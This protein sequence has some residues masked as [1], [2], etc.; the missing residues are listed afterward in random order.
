MSA[1]LYV[2]LTT[3]WQER[4][5]IAHGTTRVERGIVAALAA[6][7]VPQLQFCRYERARRSFLPVER[8]EALQVVATKEVPE[9]RRNPPAKWRK[10]SILAMGKRMEVWI[11]RN[12]RDRL[13]Q[14]TSEETLA[15]NSTP[16]FSPSSTVLFPGELQRQDFAVLMQLKAQLSLRLAF[17][18]YD[19]L[20]VLPDDDPRLR[21]PTEHNLPSSDFIAREAA[22]V[23]SIS[24]YSRSMLLDH[25]AKRRLKKPPVD[26]IRLGHTLLAEGARSAPPSGLQ[27]GEFVLT[28]GDVVSR[29]N[30]V[31]LI[32]VWRHLLAVRPAALKPLII[33]GRVAAE[34]AWL[35][36]EIA[37]DPGLTKYVL[38]LTNVNDQQLNWLYANCLFT[39]F[40]SLSEG[41]GLPVAESLA[42]GKVC[43]A[44]SLTS[45]PEASQ[46][47]GIHLDPTDLQSWIVIVGRLLADPVELARQTRQ[48]AAFCRVTWS[49]TAADVLRSL[50]VGNE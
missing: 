45:I 23:L 4:G 44:S 27:P 14:G 35:A 9:A 37:A 42:A 18:F 19:L 46:G 28:V 49:D 30:H 39:V 3:A 33:A 26:V 36:E 7:N 2:D 29:K 34:C 13:Q 22:N 40:P 5:R 24:N 16:F 10:H 25:I 15:R 41:Y 47:F 1:R 11:R 32:N 12:I 21:D 6:L 48:V 20:N 43:V 8:S 50:N 31:L 17:I 38:L